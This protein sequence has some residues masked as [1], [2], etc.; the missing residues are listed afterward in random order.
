M[1]KLNVLVVAV[2]LACAT[3]ACADDMTLTQTY[4][5]GGSCGYEV[6]CTKGQLYPSKQNCSGAKPDVCPA[7]PAQGCATSQQDACP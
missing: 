1:K 6:M 2:V 7:S 3:E 4:A 5:G